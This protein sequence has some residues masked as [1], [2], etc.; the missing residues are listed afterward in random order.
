MPVKY[1]KSDLYLTVFS[2]REVIT[3]KPDKLYNS[4]TDETDHFF[5]HITNSIL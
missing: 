2:I 3:V 4:K 1:Q 5:P